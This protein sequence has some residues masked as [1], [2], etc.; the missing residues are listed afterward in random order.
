MEV[1]LLGLTPRFDLLPFAAPLKIGSGLIT[2]ATRLTV[3]AA[4]ESRDGRRGEGE[5]AILLSHVWAWPGPGDP[6]AKDAAMRAASGQ[7]IDLLLADGG[8]RTPLDWYAI[9][10]GARGGLGIPHLAAAV[11][12]SPVDAAIHDGAGKAAGRSSYDLLPD[13]IR[14]H[15]RAAPLPAVPVMHT[16]GLADSDDSIRT[17]IRREGI[18]GFK[19]KLCGDPAADAARTAQVFALAGREAFLS[20]DGNESYPGP[21]EVAEYLRRLPPDV[22]SALAFV[23]QPVAR[24]SQADMSGP[25]RLKPILAD[26]GWAV[27]ADLPP[28][29]ERGWSGAVLKTCKGHSAALIA[30]AMLA[31]AGRPYAIQDLTNPGI[32]LLHS[33]GLAARCHPL[34]GLEANARQYL[35]EHHPPAFPVREGVIS[36]AGLGPTGLGHHHEGSIPV[37]KE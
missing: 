12:L 10:A 35:P 28:L 32:A 14:R 27:P 22:F 36:T 30:L 16:V 18:R 37:E 11:A 33:L 29:L 24:T 20:A 25:A 5:G 34:A 13:S 1:R 15:L 19:V 8:W 31:A 3:T 23:E 9:A 6:A 2:G 17:A 21:E 4:V 26:E 7:V